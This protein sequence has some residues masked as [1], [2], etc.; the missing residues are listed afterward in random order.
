MVGKAQKSH[1]SRSGLHGG[2]SDG[3]PPIYISQAEHNSIQATSRQMFKTGSQK[4][5]ENKASLLMSHSE[6]VFM[7]SASCNL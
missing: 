7:N 1:G 6:S 5:A 3:V 4:V 2:C